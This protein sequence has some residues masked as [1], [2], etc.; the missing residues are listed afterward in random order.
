MVRTIHG[1]SCQYRSVGEED[2]EGTGYGS[3]RTGRHASLRTVNGHHDTDEL[4]PFVVAVWEES[5]GCQSYPRRRLWQN[6]RQRRLMSP[7]PSGSQPLVS[8]SS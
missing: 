1:G 4:S 7:S 6:S 5:Q 3:Q 8:I 2:G